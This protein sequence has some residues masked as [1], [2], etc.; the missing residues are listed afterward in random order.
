[1]IGL[2][3]G[4]MYTECSRAKN[5]TVKYTATIKNLIQR[6]DYVQRYCDKEE[7]KRLVVS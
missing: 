5:E 3:Y 7:R 6:S 1:M 2:R 4:H